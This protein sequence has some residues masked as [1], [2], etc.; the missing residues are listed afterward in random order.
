[1]SYK[2]PPGFLLHPGEMIVSGQFCNYI[3]RVVGLRVKTTQPLA[4]CAH[5][6]T[7]GDLLKNCRNCGS[8][9]KKP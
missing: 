2:S 5:C 7:L 1:M 3:D 8:P 4:H 9:E 6:G